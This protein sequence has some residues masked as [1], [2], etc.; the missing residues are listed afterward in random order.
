[1]TAA[2]QLTERDGRGVGA[3]A[4]GPLKRKNRVFHVFD[5]QATSCAVQQLGGSQREREG[6]IGPL[7]GISKKL[8]VSWKEN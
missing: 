3:S 5:M 2:A 6:G 1:M 4:E 8:G 7:K